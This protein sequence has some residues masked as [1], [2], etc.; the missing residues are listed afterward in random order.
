MNI[1]ELVGGKLTLS[2]SQDTLPHGIKCATFGASRVAE[3]HVALG[4]Y[5]GRLTILD[6]ER[7]SSGNSMSSNGKNGKKNE[8]NNNDPLYS[9]QAHE[10]IINAIDGIGGIHG[11]GNGAPEIV[12]GGRDG[13]VRVW[14][15]RV[16]NP[17]VSFEPT[18]TQNTQSGREREQRDCWAVA[19]GNT[20]NSEERCVCA[21][22]DN[23]DVKLFDLKTNQ[24]RWEGN[25]NNA[26]TSIQ[27]DR[28]DIEMN[29][30][31]VTT[32]ESKFRTYDLRTQ[33]KTEGFAHVSELAHRSTVWIA[34]HLPQNRDIF[35]T[36]GGNGGFNIYKYHYPN[37]RQRQHPQDSSIIGV[38]GSVELLNSRVMSSQ[39]LSSFD[40]NMDREGLCCMSFLDQSLR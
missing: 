34:K 2:S 5:N 21:G 28:P 37:K 29:K 35:M 25:C 6:L 11:F 16:S 39:P 23:G 17:V 7:M 14:D 32:L 38:P 10:G 18:Q 20:Y 13:C 30:M 36:G 22:F 8:P 15:P 1:Y 9:V 12:T 33:H 27:F 4:D 24:V 26:V 40:W 3:R 19:F 31:V